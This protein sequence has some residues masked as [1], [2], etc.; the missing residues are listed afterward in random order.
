M[1]FKRRLLVFFLTFLLI[2]LNTLAYSKYLVPGGENLGITIKS[3]GVLIVGFYDTNT[4]NNDLKLGDIITSINDTTVDSIS[5]ML[6]L[7]DKNKEKISLKV[8]YKRNN[9][10]KYTTLELEK[11]KNGVYKTGL[12]VKD[13]ITGIGTLTYINPISNKYGA[14]GHSITDSKTNIKLEIKDGKIF[15][16]EI[17]SID[18]SIDGHAGEKNAKFYFD[19]NYGTIE[20][21]LETGIFGTYNNVYNKNDAVEVLNITDVK[22]GNASIRTTLDDNKVKEYDIEILNIDTSSNTK[23]ILFKVIDKTLLSKTGGIVK[24]MS[25]SPIMQNGKII[26]AVTHT[27]ISDNA[28]GYGISIVKMLESVE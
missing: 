22:L 28:K 20:K 15:K 4:K 9:E 13:S 7:V 21:N 2:P 10:F 24:G 6:S 18:K 3:K 26:G 1:N 5:D 16:S 8:G 14:L 23:N 19:V 25:G 12:Y 17:T 11:D 27:V